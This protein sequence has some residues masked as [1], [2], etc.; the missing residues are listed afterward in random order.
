MEWVITILTLILCGVVGQQQEDSG[1]TGEIGR[2]PTT[3]TGSITTTKNSGVTTTITTLSAA[4]NQPTTQPSSRTGFPQPRYPTRDSQELLN[5][6]QTFL[7]NWLLENTTPHTTQPT[8]R[9]PPYESTHQPFRPYRPP[10]VPGL[11]GEHQEHHR[12]GGHGY[13]QPP[14]RTFSRTEYLQYLRERGQ[15]NNKL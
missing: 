4:A 3:T 10:R 15:K 7:K 1:A 2:T 13:E 11:G 14:P 8:T 12:E 5:Y 6:V 9:P